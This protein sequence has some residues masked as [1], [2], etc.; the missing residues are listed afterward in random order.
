LLQPELTPVR[1]Q[2][3]EGT[4]SLVGKLAAD[5]S[6]LKTISAWTSGRI[7]QLYLNTT[8]VDVSAGQPMVELF[9]P[10]LIVIQ[11]EL[12]Q[13]K[14]LSA[15]QGSGRSGTL[16]ADSTLEAARRR[17]RLLGVPA[18]QIESILQS[19]TL[20]DTVTISAPVSGRVLDK[21]VNAGAYVTT[22]QPL[23]S[24][25]GLETLWLELEAFE[26]Q[27]AGISP[28]Q[29]LSV[30][31]LALPGLQLDAEVMLLEPLVDASRR[32]V[33][34]RALL[35]NPDGRL[36][37]GMLARARLQDRQDNA[38]LIPVS[39][40]LQTGERAL[41]YVKLD[42]ER[43]VF[44]GREVTLGRRFGDQYE[45]LAGLSEHEL[46]VSKGAF[47]LDSELQIRG[48]PSMMAPKGGGADPHAHHG[49]AAT[50]HAPDAEPQHAVATPPS[51][52]PH[53]FHLAD[54]DE[55]K[56]LAAYQQLY[57]ALTED[58]LA[59]WQQGTTAF[60]Q[61][62][63]AIDWP[64]HLQPLVAELQ[65]GAG[66]SHHVG[67]IERAREQ[68]YRHVQALLTLAEQ[69]VLAG[70]WY[71]AYCPMARAGQG[72]AW[73]QPQSNLLNPYYGAMMLRCGDV[74]LQYPAGGEHAH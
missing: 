45:V 68:Y 38:L 35:D 12:V 22:G 48:L 66:H 73:L 17:L 42:D 18:A 32:T 29:A 37:P 31:L 9:N 36:K 43:P 24:V 71:R 52:P 53:H 20:Q 13:A 11:Q 26:H 74:E 72:A 62:V 10:D 25:L 15:A 30:E 64:E 1:R 39:A 47:R 34:V 49:H 7:E 8:G 27:L 21:F 14:Q 60:H 61:A 69:G 46:V 19:E 57:L 54:A 67:S 65:H 58:D 44:A 33:R 5:Q 41:V 2:Q 51:S 3:A 28:G 59:G 56:V 16:P 50:Q 55:A 40:A 70:G 63:A 6:R 23:F 4:L